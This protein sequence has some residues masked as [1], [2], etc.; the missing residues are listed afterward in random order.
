LKTLKVTI[1]GLMALVAFVAAGFAALL[2]PSRLWMSFWL[3]A[4]LVWLT[5]AL[6]G[7]LF[8]RGSARAFWSGFAFCGWLYLLLN[9]GPWFQDRVSPEFA[10][11][12]I[13]ELAYPWV[14]SIE[15]QVS[16][17]APR[18]LP[19]YSAYP[20]ALVEEVLSSTVPPTPSAPAPTP[21]QDLS[22]FEVRIEFVKDH[23]VQ[24]MEQDPETGLL[25]SNSIPVTFL[26][27]GHCLFCL[28]FAFI[29]G[30]VARGFALREAGS[31][32]YAPIPE[33]EPT[34]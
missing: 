13:L 17:I 7:A 19:H 9:F 25:D 16:R 26:M 10:T 28:I 29:G 34:G 5:I 12:A 3:S 4:T 27:V 14:T 6:L 31:S 30:L 2:R 11:T 15:D 24:W 18:P 22:Q 32:S 23:W 1:G 21:K 33:R 20:P 8:R